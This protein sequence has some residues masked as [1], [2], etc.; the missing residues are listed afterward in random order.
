MFF[1][2]KMS[3]TKVGHVRDVSHVKNVMHVSDVRDVPNVI[4]ITDVRHIT[5]IQCLIDGRETV[6][7]LQKNEVPKLCTLLD[8]LANQKPRGNQQ[9]LFQLQIKQVN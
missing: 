3:L 2:S 4:H 5:D 1:T 8:F 9:I 7:P 6:T